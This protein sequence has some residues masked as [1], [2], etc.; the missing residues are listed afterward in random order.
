MVTIC[1]TLSEKPGKMKYVL[2]TDKEPKEID[3][4]NEI[5]DAKNSMVISPLL[6]SMEPEIRKLFLYLS[7]A[8]KIWDEVSRSY[9]RKGMWLRFLN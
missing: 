9:P 2:G 1:E 6:N 8:K 7:T 5:W 4:E 3:P